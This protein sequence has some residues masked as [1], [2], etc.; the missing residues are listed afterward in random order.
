MASKLQSLSLQQKRKLQQF[1]DTVAAPNGN[2]NKLIEV[3]TRCKWDVNQAVDHFY[4][5]GVQ[6]TQ[7]KGAAAATGSG[8]KSFNENTAKAVFDGLAS[9]N[10]YGE[11]CMEQDAI[12]SWLTS[13]SVD[14]QEVL[15]IYIAMHM[16]AAFMGEFK[17]AE[18]KTGCTAF[19]VDSVDSWK[20]IVSRLRQDASTATNKHEIY[21]YAFSF[22]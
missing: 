20:A 14:P 13:I 9:Q 2:E 15:A 12:E 6:L 17:W 7:P 1:S 11:T 18:F 16:K 3:L 5:H 8:G 4:S 21:K 22:A 19:G 10:E